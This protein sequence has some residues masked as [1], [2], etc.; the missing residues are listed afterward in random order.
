MKLQLIHLNGNEISDPHRKHYR[1]FSELIPRTPLISTN[2]PLIVST[3]EKDTLST[4]TP[5][6]DFLII[7]QSVE[8]IH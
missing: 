7:I 6:V 3:N 4:Q 1:L 2:N 8:K 5:Q